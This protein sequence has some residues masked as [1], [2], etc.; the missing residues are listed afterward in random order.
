VEAGEAMTSSHITL[1][2]TPSIS[3]FPFTHAPNS[4]LESLQAATYIP[5]DTG[6]ESG[7]I[8]TFSI[9]FGGGDRPR[10]EE[11][12]SGGE[13]EDDEDEDDEDEE[14]ADDEEDA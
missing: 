14:D 10:A 6:I 7:S 1:N 8:F 2:P 5:E 4:A 13:D 3:R 12:W 11:T 9:V